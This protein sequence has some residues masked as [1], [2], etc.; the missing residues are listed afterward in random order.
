MSNAEQVTPDAIRTRLGTL[1]DAYRVVLQADERRLHEAM[2][3][4]ERSCWAASMLR[5]A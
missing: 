2:L 5:A 4:Y 3:E 1:V